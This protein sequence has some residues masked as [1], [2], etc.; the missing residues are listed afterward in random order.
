MLLH[1]LRLEMCWENKCVRVNVSYSLGIPL[2]QM[3]VEP[4]GAGQEGLSSRM[5]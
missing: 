4:A 3:L 1:E 5:G 2:L